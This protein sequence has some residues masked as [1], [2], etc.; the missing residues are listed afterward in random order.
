MTA[1]LERGEYSAACPGRTL[2]PGKDPV[3]ILQEAGWAPGPVWRGGK[4]PRRDSIPDRPARSQS[5]YR[6]SYPAHIIQCSKNNYY[7]QINRTY[8]LELELRLPCVMCESYIVWA[9]DRILYFSAWCIMWA[10]CFKVLILRDV[11]YLQRCCWKVWTILDCYIVLN[12]K[13]LPFDT[14]IP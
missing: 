4:S 7:T 3:P 2:P 14:G 6:L 10:L 13:Q 8:W 12:G 11:V 9:K 5:L 1:A